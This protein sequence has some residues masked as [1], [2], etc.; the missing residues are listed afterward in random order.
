[1]ALNTL[2]WIIIIS[3]L[4]FFLIVG[5]LFRKRASEGMESFFVS[6][7]ALPWW[8]AGTSMVATTFAA[9]TPLAVTGMVAANGIA[10]NWLW[11]NMMASAVLTVFL[12][13]HLWRR[14]GVITDVEFSELRYGGAPAAFLRAFRAA[15]LAL[16]INLIIMGWVMHAMA[17][18]MGVV[19]GTGMWTSIAICLVVVLIYVTL[20]GLW[21]VVVTDFLQFGL[22]MLGAVLLAIFAVREVG[23]L[24]GLIGSI[25]E[26]GGGE[27]TMLK[28]LPF[29]EA[30][31]MP[32]TTILVYLGVQW[33]ASWYPGAEPGGGGYIAQRILSTKD[34]RHSVLATLW[35]T[36]AHYVLRPWPWIMVALAS[37]LL[38]PGL[39]DAEIGYV[40]AMRDLLPAGLLG[41]MVA[42]FAAAFM[43]TISTQLNWGSSYL[44]N[45]IYRRF[46]RRDGSETHYVLASRLA[47]VLLAG[48]GALT[49][50]TM[51]SV[52]GA[53]KFLLAIGAGTGPVYLLRWY[54]W[55]INAWSE[56]SAMAA[57]LIVSLI[58]QWIFG[59]DVNAP[60]DFALVMLLTVVLTSVVWLTVT[61]MTG[62]ED[63]SVLDRFYEKVRPTGRGWRRV[64][65]RVGLTSSD[66]PLSVSF[67]YWILGCVVVFTSLFG[68][69][70][71]LVGSTAAGIIMLVCS[72]GVGW[73][74]WSRLSNP[75]S[76]SPSH[77]S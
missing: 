63:E 23:G 27:P 4:V 40:Y 24:S 52:E 7:R 56:V 74:L 45:D 65:E 59:L 33:W 8:L 55:R 38:Y 67:Y 34:E 71:L 43:S 68:I 44:V 58:L 14:S 66:R 2:D 77:H 54:W 15:Y 18:V 41:M 5:V 61:C 29:G 16:P 22:A 50:A 64:S 6:G 26:L 72:V 57:A 70:H 32:L 1:M 49:A 39:E 35:F 48:L 42:S 9:D 73:F 37:V 46:L 31:W 30:A 51:G 17:K 20:S 21:G 69:G 36:I 47:T 13:A 19:L 75:E 3:L 25:T 62:P 28:M 60:S 76:L 12:Y 10:G 11:W 53:W